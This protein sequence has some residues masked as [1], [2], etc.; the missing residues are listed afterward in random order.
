[1]IQIKSKTVA[2]S[3]PNFPSN[4]VTVAKNHIYESGVSLQ[5]GLVCQLLRFPILYNLLDLYIVDTLL[6]TER[7]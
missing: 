3:T 6:L 4:A 5:M 1:M 2:D 7:Y